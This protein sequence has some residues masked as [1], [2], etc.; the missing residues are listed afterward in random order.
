MFIGSLLTQ[1][2]CAYQSEYFLRGDFYARIPNQD[3]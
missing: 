1:A 3:I 2:Q